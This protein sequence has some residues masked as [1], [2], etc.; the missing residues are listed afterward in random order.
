MLVLTH[1]VQDRIYLGDEIVIT[2]VDIQRG[3]V[4]LGFDAPGDIPIRRGDMSPESLPP[5]PPVDM[6]ALEDVLALCRERVASGLSPLPLR[7]AVQWLR[8]GP[9]ASADGEA[10][11]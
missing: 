1:S 2:V 4:R 3:K 7:E 8:M 6:A 9:V 10:V 5:G 11:E